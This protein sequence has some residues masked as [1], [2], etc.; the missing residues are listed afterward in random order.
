MYIVNAEMRL[1][2]C[3]PNFDIQHNCPAKTA[4]SE[5]LQPVFQQ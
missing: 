2:T 3:T 4:K 1:V 5:H